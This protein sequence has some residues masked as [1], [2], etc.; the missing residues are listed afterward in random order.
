MKF[1]AL[2]TDLSKFFDSVD[3]GQ[4]LVV[5]HALGAPDM[6]VNVIRD[7]YRKLRRV[8]TFK[9]AWSDSWIEA[10]VGLLQ[11]RPLSM[12]CG[13][14]YGRLASRHQAGCRSS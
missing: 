5:L 14:N 4:A 9:G 11:G 12:L 8:F 2:A 7:F 1:A 3:V 13:S 10:T 6:L